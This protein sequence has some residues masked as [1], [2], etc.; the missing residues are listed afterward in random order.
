MPGAR[1][2]VPP[3]VKR[4]LRQQ[5]GFG[6]CICGLPIYQYHHII[7]WAADQHFRPD[8]MMLLCP[9]H[10][11]MATKGAMSEVKQ[12]EAKENPHNIWDGV[13]LGELTVDQQFLAIRVGG[14]IL[15]DD[16]PLI[17]IDGEPLLS[18]KI[19]CGRMMLSITL[20]D[21]AGNLLVE[22]VDNEWITGD[23]LPWDIESGH[24]RLKLRAKAFDVRLDVD[25]RASPVDLRAR[26]WHHGVS[27][28][29][30]GSG[31]HTHGSLRAG[32]ANLGL[33]CTPLNFD[34]NGGTS[35]G[36]SKGGLIVSEP[37]PT[38][39][40]IKCVQGFAEMRTGRL[41]VEATKDP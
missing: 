11:D 24:Q 32:F 15:V 8:D 10:H 29:L 12:R 31:I 6:C 41:H 16:G 36:G 13:T 34:T 25:A 18:T 5:A 19:D 7:P 26:L 28:H 4:E 33:I 21:R 40:L 23:P 27:V 14:V 38:R 22:I 17:L 1:P 9:L 30:K 20:Y 37:D 39:R 2:S 3:S 35:I